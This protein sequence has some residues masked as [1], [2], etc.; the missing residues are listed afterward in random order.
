ML[1]RF[2][3]CKKLCKIMH[4]DFPL[5]KMTNI[6]KIIIHNKINTFVG[7]LGNLTWLSF[8]VFLFLALS[9]THTSVHSHAL[10]PF[11]YR[12]SSPINKSK[13]SKWDRGFSSRP[14]TYPPTALRTLAQRKHMQKG[15]T[16]TQPVTVLF[17]CGRRPSH[18][19]EKYDVSSS[20]APCCADAP[21]KPAAAADA[22]N[23][24]RK[25]KLFD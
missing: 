20:S 3:F 14:S 23:P 10:K 6:I 19:E 4:Y 16:H 15:G 21:I 8:S 13:A 22:N 24:Q 2:F 5:N 11:N 7:E 9:L 25:G 12:I 17:L 18:G 1:E